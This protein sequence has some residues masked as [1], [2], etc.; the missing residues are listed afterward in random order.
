MKS[1]AVDSP[2][3]NLSM[4]SVEHMQRLCEQHGVR[5]TSKRSLVLCALMRSDKALSAYELVD[6]CNSEFGSEILANSAYRILDFL[7][8]KH[9]VHKLGLVNKYV[10][11]AH[12]GRT[13]QHPLSQFL[14][15][16]KCQRVEEIC[17][18][19]QRETALRRDMH[20]AGFHLLS[21]QLEFNGVCERCM[22]ESL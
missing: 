6:R 18:E 7:E 5:L 20:E 13:Q 9:L 16:V 11:C 19:A 12:V 8:G 17:I 4:D 21:P 3:K 2:Q 14:I 1:L 15:C 10:A 22:H